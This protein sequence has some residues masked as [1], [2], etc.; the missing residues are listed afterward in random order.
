M[1]LNWMKTIQ[2]E[3][4][5]HSWLEMSE[6]LYIAIQILIWSSHVSIKESTSNMYQRNM[7]RLPLKSL[8]SNL[9]R[10]IRHILSR[11]KK[12]LLMLLLLKKY[13][14]ALIKPIKSFLI[15]RIIPSFL[16]NQ[17]RF[18]FYIRCLNKFKLHSMK[19]LRSQQ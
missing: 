3:V 15:L 8:N 1:F 12:S 17:Y 4:H 18:H 16:N 6:L 5:C 2:S 9:T 10:L 14:A 11:K 19:M 7:L 13:Q